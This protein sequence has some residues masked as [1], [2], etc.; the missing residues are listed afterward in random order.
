MYKSAL[1]NY[2]RFLQSPSR[3][4]AILKTV[5]YTLW[6]LSRFY[7]NKLQ[8]SM[9]TT[10]SGEI[11]WTRYLLRFFGWPAALEGIES[12][13]W[14]DSKGL[15]KAMAWTMVAY[16]PLEHLA[17]LY[18]KV[19]DA[20]PTTIPASIGTSFWS[21]RRSNTNNHNKYDSEYTISSTATT[22]TCSRQ[23]V[24]APPS[25]L[26]AKAS[27]WSCRFWLAY[28]VL[29]IARSMLAMQ[30]VRRKMKQNNDGGGGGD[31]D[32]KKTKTKPPPNGQPQE[33]EQLQSDATVDVLDLGTM[34][35][36]RMQ[37]VR[38]LLYVLPAIHWSLPNWDTQPWLSDTVVNGLCWLESIVG[39][40][41]GIHN[42][43]QT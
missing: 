30:N 1:V 5:Q 3:Q 28:L 42:F 13:S 25:R 41:Q 29:D 8:Q 21:W 14:A 6:L 4:E 23:M 20:M 33:P 22:A 26:A 7:R 34:R 31:A 19:P 37:L 35:T 16:Y 2:L 43:R 27:A 11:S 36:E 24:A 12:G 9:L 40:M 32:G 10:V 39:L 38:D 18:W 15:G 17:Y